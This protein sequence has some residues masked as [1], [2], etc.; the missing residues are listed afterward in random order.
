[1]AETKDGIYTEVNA[2]NAAKFCL[3]GAIQYIYG[4]N[5]SDIF[6]KL[7]PVVK[8]YSLGR[9]FNPVSFNDAASTTIEDIRRVVAIANI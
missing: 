9:I 6:N 4:N 1:L 2:A 8:G 5:S 7:Y 3:S